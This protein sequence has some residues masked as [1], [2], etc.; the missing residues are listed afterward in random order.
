MGRQS[1]SEWQDAYAIDR[2]GAL[3]DE[4][5]ALLG[6]GVPAESIEEASR[7]IGLKAGALGL[8]DEV[9]LAAADKVVHAAPREGHGRGHGH[10]HDHDHDHS[11][12]HSHDHDH[13][14]CSHHSHDAAP[15]QPPR[16][17]TKEAVYVVEKM[18]HGFRRMGR[19]AGGGFYEYAPDEAPALWPGL[20]Q[21]ERR[22]RKLTQRDIE[23]R[24]KYAQLLVNERLGQSGVAGLGSA[25]SLISEMG[26]DGFAQR[27]AE[28]CAAY[29]TRFTLPSALRDRHARN[30]D[31][32]T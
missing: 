25:S 15:V 13:D 18:S 10:D 20:R 3:I 14:Q 27:C 12:S 31:P 17:L 6:E 19:A 8:L 4:A 1:D 2:Y 28:L 22:A 24:L 32:G 26:F 5:L 7:A 9:S 21:F 29:G 11:H 30:T 16:E 23:D